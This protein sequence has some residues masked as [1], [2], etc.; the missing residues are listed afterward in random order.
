MKL[1]LI[2]FLIF[3]SQT[4]FAKK[5]EGNIFQ[6]YGVM[7]SFMGEKISFFDACINDKKQLTEV[8]NALKSEFVLWKNRHTYADQIRNH[9]NAKLNE[10]YSPE[11]VN[12]FLSSAKAS[13]DA[14]DKTVKK[15]L[16]TNELGCSYFLLWVSNKKNDFNVLFK[17]DYINLI[18]FLQK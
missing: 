17:N 7:I 13:I 9:F 18:N 5:I 10:N 4:I 16:N 3:I 15:D 12:K 2:V 6:S 11:E 8:K 14:I 1:P